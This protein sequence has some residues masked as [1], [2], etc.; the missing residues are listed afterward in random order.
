M[1]DRARRQQ[2]AHYTSERDVAL[3]A[4]RFIASTR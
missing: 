1:E 4:E 2:G 3:E